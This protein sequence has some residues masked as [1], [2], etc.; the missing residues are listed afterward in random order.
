MINSIEEL[1]EIYGLPSGRAK[2]K[3]LSELEQHAINFITTSPFMV[4]SSYDENGHCDNSPRGGSP[5]FVKVI[6]SKTIAFCDAKGNNRIDTLRNIVQTKQV[7]LLFL[8][9]GIEETLRLN[10]IAKISKSTEHL[11]LFQN[12]KIPPKT[13][14]FIE[15][16]EVFLHCA[17]AMMR[18]KIWLDDFK[19]SNREDFPTMG[20]MLKDQLKGPEEVESY[21]DMV[22]RYKADL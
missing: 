3:S 17:K 4:I 15:I 7:G 18:S 21:Q 2:N 19:I 13:V 8:I 10:G 11:A 22:K 20:Q 5:G 16:Q 12:E 14:I 1:E 6:D 9:P